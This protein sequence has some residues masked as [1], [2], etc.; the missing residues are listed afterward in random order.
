MRALA[1]GAINP[2]LIHVVERFPTAGEDVRSLS[3]RLT[4][5]GKATNAAV[6]LAAWNVET[7][8][9]GLVLGSDALGAALIDAI[10][11]PLLNR[12]WVERDPA[13]ATRHC[14]ILLTPDGDRTIVC[15]GYEDARW[16]EVPEDAWKGVDVVVLD[17]F[18][19]AAADAVARDARRRRIPVVWLDAPNPP[20]APVELVV[21]SRN[22]RSESEAAE[23][24]ATQQA[25]YLTAG[26]DP[27]VVWWAGERFTIQP[28]QVA[29]ADT[30]GAGDVTAAACA[31]G[32]ASGWGPLETARWAAAAGSASAAASRAHP[33]TRAVVDELVAGQRDRHGAHPDC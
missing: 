23:L 9:L 2:D 11:H 26:A 19:G 7:H 17:G 12:K 29:V 4:W 10:D 32:I 31:L 15:T 22:E 5:G 8:L 18:A 20:P 1:Y 14:V 16:Q 3:W 30:T 28:P 6:A 27:V 21:W 33:P 24:V 25:V 13:E